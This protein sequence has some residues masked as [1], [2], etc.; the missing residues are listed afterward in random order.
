ML[1]PS[2]RDRLSTLLSSSADRG[3]GALVNYEVGGEIRG[4]DA[5][6]HALTTTIH[7]GRR[8]KSIREI[9]PTDW[10]AKGVGHDVRWMVAKH[11]V[12]RVIPE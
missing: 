8:G 2:T 4:P 10:V 5:P 3:G 11:E 1:Q 6:I 9:L 12:R 7:T